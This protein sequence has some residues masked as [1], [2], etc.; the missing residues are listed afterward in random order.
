MSTIFE[1]LKEVMQKHDYQRLEKSMMDIAALVR[2]REGKTI[3]TI[4]NR[5]SNSWR[6]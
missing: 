5:T 2:E 6:H 3:L 1:N 4:G